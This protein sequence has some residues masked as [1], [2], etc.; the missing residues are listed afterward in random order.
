MN[1]AERPRPGSMLHEVRRRFALLPSRERTRWAALLPLGA[2]SAFL[3]ALA[4]AL[5]YGL[6]AVLSGVGVAPAGVAGGLA[7]T[8]AR[9]GGGSLAVGFAMAAAITH[10]LRSGLLL[11]TVA[12]HARV[13]GDAAAAVSTRVLRAYFTAPYVFHLRRSSTD[14]AQNVILAVPALLELFAALTTL[15]TELLVVAALAA[16]LCTVAPFETLV[17][18]SVIVGPL[19][20]FLR[21]SRGAY[22]RFGARN[23][24]LGLRIAD[25][26]QK[27]FGAIKEVKVLGRERFFYDSIALGQQE[28]A[29]VAIAHAALET[30]P[31]LLTEAAFVLGMLVLVLV[32]SGRTSGRTGLLPF[33]G[34]YAYAGFRLI[35]AAHRIA[36]QLGSARYRVAATAPLCDDLA[37]LDRLAGAAD[38]EA[39]G[40]TRF[41]ADIRLERVLYAYDPGGPAILRDLDLVIHRGE[42]V[43]IVG[44]SGAGKSTLVDLILGLLDPVAG[45]VVV[46]DVPVADRRG[47]WQRQI[48][49]VPQDPVLIDDTLR[50]NIAFGIGDA[51]IDDAAVRAAVHVAQLDE[52]VASLPEGLDSILGERGVRLSG[53]ER[54][55]VSMAR[56]LYHDPEVLVLDEATSAL[57]PGTEREVTRAIDRMRGEKTLIVIAHAL[58]TVERCDRLALLRDGKIIAEGTYEELLRT[59]PAFR[60]IAAMEPTA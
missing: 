55:R 47:A 16:V 53:G 1:E 10:L 31:R 11:L 41:R 22:A 15:G 30:V 37:A 3:E 44:A 49:Y 17:A 9:L 6:V 35:P 7:T 50:R 59:S 46:D 23:H 52:L 4:A 36:L 51:E 45:R 39:P 40:P 12:C 8:V 26:L 43:A 19:V 27:A 18:T 34:L 2:A 25:G 60:V 20:P 29:R 33:I 54:Q 14:R 38:V 32:L 58:S 13:A 48:G 5:V 24:A 57:D 28:R 42:C 56:A 21:L